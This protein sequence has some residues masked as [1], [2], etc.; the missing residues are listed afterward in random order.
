METACEEQA[1]AIKARILK[2]LVLFAELIEKGKN[3]SLKK[4]AIEAVKTT[5]VE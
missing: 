4:A 5:V 1:P 3:G 2:P